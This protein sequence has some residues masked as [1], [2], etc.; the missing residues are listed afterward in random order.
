[1]KKSILVVAASIALTL[2]LAGCEENVQTVAEKADQANR[3]AQDDL[4]A[5]A[6]QVVPVPHIT[7]SIDPHSIELYSL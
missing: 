4:K 1:M 7:K 2:S 6:I 3:Q 5:R